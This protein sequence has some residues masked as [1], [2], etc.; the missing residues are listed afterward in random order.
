MVADGIAREV[1]ANKT[2]VE[3]ETAKASILAEECAGI[4][5][6]ATEIREDAERDLEAAVPA[7]ERAMEA[8]NTLDKKDLGECRTMST[9][10]SGVGDVF[11]AV[12]VLL[13]GEDWRC[14]GKE[15]GDCSKLPPH[16]F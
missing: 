8:L 11:A 14:G 9:P 13:A 15:K 1:L 7:V 16:S 10:P 12:V 2:V 5:A 6:R 3:A 4:A